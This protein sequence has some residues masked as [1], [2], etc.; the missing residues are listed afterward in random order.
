MVVVSRCHKGPKP[1]SSA[2][3]HYL[4]GTSQSYSLPLNLLNLTIRSF[5]C[6]SFCL[7][8]L[9][10]NFLR[11]SHPICKIYIFS[12]QLWWWWR[13][14]IPKA[15]DSEG[16]FLLEPWLSPFPSWWALLL[17]S[18]AMNQIDWSP[19]L[20]HCLPCVF[21]N[22]LNIM[23][24]HFWCSQRIIAQIKLVLSQK[25]KKK[26]YLYKETCYLFC[27]FLYFLFHNNLSLFHFFSTK[28]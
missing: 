11:F 2:V 1:H 10:L 22:L 15:K 28:Y 20:M 14:R 21:D 25:K 13:W 27:L 4:Q 18:Q 6:Y 26:T 17:A 7:G 24:H 16:W 8:C 3:Y 23:S 5:A 19:P 12:I 9:P